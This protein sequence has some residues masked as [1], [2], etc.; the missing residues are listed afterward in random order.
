ME[1]VVSSAI[2]LGHMGDR[3]DIALACV[4]LASSAGRWGRAR[5]GRG[6]QITG[7][8]MGLARGCRVPALGGVSTM[9]K[10]VPSRPPH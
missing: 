10:Y 4:Y 9:C 5:L 2:P 7:P 1:E 3:S 6:G 8:A